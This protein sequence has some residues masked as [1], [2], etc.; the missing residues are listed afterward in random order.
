LTADRIL[1]QGEHYV[2]MDFGGRR[3]AQFSAAGVRMEGCSFEG[4]R[5]DSCSFGGGTTTSEYVNCNFSESRLRMMSGGFARFVDC[6]F[7]KADIENWLCF[8]VEVV[9]CTF[10]GRLRGVVFN[11]TVPTKDRDLLRRTVNEF[12]GNDFSRAAFDNVAFGTGIDL[13]LQRLPEGDQ[14]VFLPDAMAQ[15]RRARIAYNA[16]TDQEQ[17]SAARGFLMATESDVAAGQ[18]QLLIRVDD[19]PRKMRPAI[20]ALLTAATGHAADGR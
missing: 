20:R 13:R 14:Y 11:G 8:A 5:I 17:K 18:E 1:L 9:N 3:L 19:Y 2:G 15:L 4:A 6:S 7:E 10:S 12:D 16:W